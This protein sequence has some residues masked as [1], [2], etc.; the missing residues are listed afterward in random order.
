MK[1]KHTIHISEAETYTPPR[2]TGTL[3]YRLAGKGGGL[4]TEH[5]EIILGELERGG[6]AEYHYHKGSE[7]AIFILEGRCS[8]TFQD[9]TQEEAGKG[10]LVILPKGLAHRVLVTEKLRGVIIYSPKLKEGDILPFT[11]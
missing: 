11:K 5:L 10:D 8:I 2:H 7:Q 6:E 3:N 1:R 9:G 4:P